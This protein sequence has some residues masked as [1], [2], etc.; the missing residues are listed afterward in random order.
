MFFFLAPFGFLFF[1]ILQKQTKMEYARVEKLVARHLPQ[2]AYFQSICQENNRIVLVNYVYHYL[3]KL[4]NGPMLN[5]R[6]ILLLHL[7]A[8]RSGSSTELP[9]GR[10]QLNMFCETNAV[11]TANLHLLKP[12]VI[13]TTD[14]CC[15]IC[16]LAIPD[17]SVAYEL[18]CGHQFHLRHERK[19]WN[20]IHWL[21]NTNICPAPTCGLPVI[22]SMQK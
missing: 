12:I 21:K 6:D 2:C 8:L 17:G 20:L 1:S 3:T 11:P 5:C 15:S 16:S 14:V 9:E 10:T 7:Y 22:L 19:E 18:P 13:Q 4:C